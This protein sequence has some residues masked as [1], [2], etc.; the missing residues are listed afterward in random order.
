MTDWEGTSCVRYHKKEHVMKHQFLGRLYQSALLSKCFT[1]RKNASESLRSANVDGQL[2]VDNYCR[3]EGLW[4][5]KLEWPRLQ[6]SN[7]FCRRKSSRDRRWPIFNKYG[8]FWGRLHELKS[9]FPQHYL[10]C[11]SQWSKNIGP[12][13]VVSVA[14]RRIN[15]PRITDG[16]WLRWL[17]RFRTFEYLS[18]RRVGSRNRQ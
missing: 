14:H 6:R 9:V 2:K 11:V 7:S 10:F 5:I 8:A 18:A 1:V 3:W 15:S 17:F 13:L 4:Q 12:H 16:R